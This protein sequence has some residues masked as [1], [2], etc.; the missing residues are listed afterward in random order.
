MLHEWL[1][2]L[3]LIGFGWGFSIMVFCLGLVF[4]ICLLVAALRVVL[5]V[6]RWGHLT[7]LA[8]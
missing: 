8:S 5:E 7:S 4:G 3:R 1:T 2:S 6:V